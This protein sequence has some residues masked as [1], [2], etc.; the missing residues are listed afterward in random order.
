MK[1]VLV[2]VLSLS[3]VLPALAGSVSGFVRDAADGEAMISASVYLEEI[4][5]GGTSNISGYYVIPGIPAGTY[6][7][8]TSFIGYATTRRSFEVGEGDDVKIDLDLQAEAVGIDEVVVRADSVRTAVKLFRKPV[9]EIKLT[10]RQISQIPQVAEAD[11]LRS[12]QTLPGILPLSDFSSALYVRGGTPDQ[13]LYMIDGTDVYNPEHAFGLFSTFNSDAI[14]QVELSKG[15]FGADYGGRLSSILDVTNLDGNREEFEGTAAISLLSAKTTLQMP[16]GQRGSLSGSAR[17]TYFDQTVGRSLDDIPDYY[18]YDGNIKAY[19]ELNDNNKLTLSGYGG[20]DFL[21]IIFNESA[22]NDTGISTDWGNKTG[23][24]RWTRVFSPRVFGNFWITG[25]RFTSDFTF[26]EIDIFE[27][28]LVTDLTVKGNFEYIHSS[29][30]T[31]KF[32]FEQ[33]NLHVKFRQDFPGGLVDVDTRPEQYTLYGLGNWRPNSFWDIEAGLRYNIFASERT[34]HNLAPRLALKYRLTE[35]TSLKGAAGV[36]YQ[37]LHR[38]PR[39]IATDIW[40]TSNDFQD[41]SKSVHLI[42]GAQREVAGNYQLEVET[43]YKTYSDIYAF[44]QTFLTELEETSFNAANEPIF[45]STR[46]IFNSGKGASLGIE[47]LL[48]KDSGAISGWLGYSL[49]RTE[50]EFPTIN[51]GRDFFPRHDRTSTVNLV[52]N[53]DIK[54]SWRKLRGRPKGPDRGRWTFGINAV[55]STGQPFTE[56]GSGYFA[57]PD[58]GRFDQFGNPD[59]NL[60]Y[61]PTKINNIRLPHYAR[62]DLSLTYKRQFKNWSIAPY[63]QFFNAGNRKNVWFVDYD[64]SNGVPDVD[65]TNMFPLLPTIG[66]N[67]EF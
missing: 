51:L 10:G 29:A 54:N 14:K 9:S 36:Y 39:F 16:L 50:Y 3:T 31:G 12:L 21:D 30:L 66:V 25:S 34:F 43:Y 46:G 56:P 7:L 61:A 6:T 63:I 2:L 42:F 59:F 40:T 4:E 13:N 65:T 17:R 32:G 48:R 55:Y 67:L 18:F 64:F 11:L 57:R 38:I 20:R 24:V 5:L 33:K 47:A 37:Y 23:S 35:T 1:F 52:G 49:A 41:A 27:R 19:I 60:A 28:N 8:V 53:I 15:G 45:A 62:L 58:R 26:E 22:D 44:N